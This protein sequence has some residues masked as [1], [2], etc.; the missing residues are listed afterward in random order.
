MKVAFFDAKAYDIE[1][2]NKVNERYKCDITYFESRLKNNNVALTKGF[3]VVCI[4]V[5]DI[6]DKNIIDSLVANG[7]K[8]IAL[9]CAGYNNIDFKSINDQIKVVRVPSYS[10]YSI[11]EHTV[12]LIL[13]LNRKIHRAYLRTKEANFSL[14]GLLG[15]DLFGK[16][17]G[18]IGT[19]RIAKIVIN[20]LRGF[21]MKV[22]AYDLY[23]DEKAAKDMGFEYVA[24]DTLYANSDIISLHCPLTAE[25][26]YMINRESIGKMK[27]GVMIVNTGRGKLIET[28]A[29]IN[30]LKSKKIGMA[31]LDVYEE[32]ADY[33]FEDYS[34]KIL[35]DDILARLL[36]FNNVLVTSHQAFFTEEALGDIAEITLKNIRDFERGRELENEVKYICDEK[37]CSWR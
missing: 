27:E 4:F 1:S 17:A 33:F 30:G 3:D 11:A 23:R 7:V 18:I 8:L 6:I 25:T 16:T 9:R 10:P 20:I 21:G 28:T 31:A 24:L 19:G 26:E 2:F 15:F 14:N 37:G 5:N 22:I 13:S 32:E 34:D 35:N 29:L 36:T 12:A